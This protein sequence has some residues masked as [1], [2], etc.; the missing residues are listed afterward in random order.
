MK[1]GAGAG[2]GANA[3][4]MRIRVRIVGELRENGRG[5]GVV[6]EKGV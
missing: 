3:D 5:G 6:G 4:E 2:P 1:G